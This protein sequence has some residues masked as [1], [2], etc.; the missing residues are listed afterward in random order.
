[1]HCLDL[2]PTLQKTNFDEVVE[3]TEGSSINLTVQVFS[4]LPLNSEP[5]WLKMNGILSS[6]NVINHIYI[7]DAITFTSLELYNVSH[8]DD[9]GIYSLI[10]SNRCGSSS[11]I[12]YISVKGNKKA[13]YVLA[14]YIAS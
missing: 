10:A 8:T 7:S 2:P 11:F 6:G 9:T 1:M 13:A 4:S 3:V 14:S 5:V 12:V